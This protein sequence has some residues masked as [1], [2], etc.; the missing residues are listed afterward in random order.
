MGIF[1]TNL[2][3]IAVVRFRK[4]VR[5]NLCLE[6]LFL[7]EPGSLVN[8]GV[9]DI[10]AKNSNT[11][12]LVDGVYHDLEISR[13]HHA[14]LKLVRDDGSEFWARISGRAFDQ[15]H[16][17]AGSAWL[18]EDITQRHEAEHALMRANSEM[19]Q[20]VNERTAELA[21]ANAQLQEEIFERMQTEQRVWHLAHHDTLTGLPNRALLQDR[22][23]QA[24][25][26]AGRHDSRVAVMFLDLDRFKSI[27][28][29]LGHSVGDELLKRV[30][31]RQAALAGYRL[32]DEIKSHLR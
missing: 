25:T 30:A 8:R 21:A 2:I 15:A 19:E 9:A 27:N 1:E 7:A 14:E 26:Q 3:G 18:V 20:R 4:I 17:E 5:N 11:D 16:P 13:G 10:M 23:D 28:D 31:E 6:Q 24:L 12:G 22:L 32:A 29:T